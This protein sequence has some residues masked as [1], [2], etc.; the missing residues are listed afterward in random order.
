[1]RCVR[2]NQLCRIRV[3][4]ERKRRARTEFLL[5]LNHVDALGA[6]LMS[7]HP[8]SAKTLAK[9]DTIIEWMILP[10]E[11]KTLEPPTVRERKS[12]RKTLAKKNAM[13][14]MLTMLPNEMP[15]TS[16]V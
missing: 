3:E 8:N 6:H 11:N 2:R 5:A 10:G 12:V 9:S 16:S 1:M 13:L 14:T 15:Q 4:R 7:N